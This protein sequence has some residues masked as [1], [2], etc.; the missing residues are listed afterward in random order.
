MSTSESREIAPLGD[1]I[2]K[3]LRVLSAA[4]SRRRP[5]LA[6]D[7]EEAAD[8]IDR[9]QGVVDHLAELLSSYSCG[10]GDLYTPPAV[11]WECE[12]CRG[13]A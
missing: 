8:E 7:L 12:N 1:G 3:H 6:A 5:R 9:L 13:E 2:A 10:C 11:D 4:H